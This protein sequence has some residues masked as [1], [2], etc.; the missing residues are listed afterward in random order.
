[1]KVL[2]LSQVL[3][4]LPDSGPKIKTGTV[5]RY[6][7]ERHEVTLVSFVR[8][9]QSADVAHLRGTGGLS[10]RCRWSACRAGRPGDGS[11]HARRATLDD[12]TRWPGGGGSAVWWAT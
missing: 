6:L 7:V 11:Q 10:T 1:M 12:S 5:L 2:L 4:Y 3:R 8:G 9:D